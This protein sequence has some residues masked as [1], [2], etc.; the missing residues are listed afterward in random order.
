MPPLARDQ[1]V[2]PASERTSLVAREEEEK[3][4]MERFHKTWN[5]VQIMY[6]IPRF[7]YLWAVFTCAVSGKPLPPPLSL[8]YLKPRERKIW[9]ENDIDPGEANSIPAKEYTMHKLL[10]TFSPDS[11]CSS[12]PPKPTLLTTVPLS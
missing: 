4:K 5:H 2:M 3:R 11:V 6:L 7:M 10:L 1:S 8:D 9:L 12:Y